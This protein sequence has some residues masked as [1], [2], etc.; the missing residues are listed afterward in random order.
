[1]I[2]TK[3]SEFA[4]PAKRIQGASII[5]R[6]EIG[7]LIEKAKKVAKYY[8]L[9]TEC[10]VSIRNFSGHSIERLE[11]IKNIRF[12]KFCKTHFRAPSKAWAD[13]EYPCSQ[14][15]INAISE[16][17]RMGSSYIYLCK[18]GFTFWA[19]PLYSGGRYI[20][21]VISGYILGIKRGEAEKKFCS[22]CR[23]EK[24][25]EEILCFLNETPEKNPDEV[26]ALAQMLLVCAGVISGRESPPANTAAEHTGDSENRARKIQEPLKPESSLEKERT[27]LAALRHGDAA[28]GRKIL[29]ELIHIFRAAGNDNFEFVQFRAIELVTFLSRTAAFNA[30]EDSAVLEDNNRHLKR[31]QDSRTIEELTENLHKIMENMA[32]QVFFFKGIRHA[33]ALRRAERYIWENYTR[34]ISLKEIAGAS[35]LSAPYFSSV[36]KEEMGENLSTHLNRL[37]VEKAS[38]MLSETELSLNEIAGACGFEDQSWFSKIFKI[39]TGLSPGKYRELGGNILPAGN[40]EA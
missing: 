6:R 3:S 40:R 23:T 29:D 32:S 39:Y 34:K 35:G 9:A 15:H 30:C 20:G 25:A 33:S 1:M 27:L 19:S 17:R 11:N 12:C 10:A 26:K 8:E 28:T 38:V 16:S 4:A 22:L 5:D 21:S 14:K 13:N 7:P 36:F 2:T 18:M 24:E 31:L 37:R